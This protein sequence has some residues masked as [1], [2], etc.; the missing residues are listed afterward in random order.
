MNSFSAKMEADYIDEA[1]SENPALAI[2]GDCR[3]ESR[4]SLMKKKA[5]RK[6]YEIEGQRLDQGEVM[7]WIVERVADA[8]RPLSLKALAQ[9]KGAPSLR[10]I[11]GWRRDFPSFDQELTVAENIRAMLLAEE[12]VEVVMDEYDPKAAGLVKAKAESLRWMASK[13]D[14]GKFAD[15]KIDKNDDQFKDSSN[16]QIMDALREAI[17]AN[18][19]ILKTLSY[20]ER[21]QFEE[22]GVI[23][24]TPEPEDESVS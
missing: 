18:S 21:K 11:Y 24:V 4:V 14:P 8:N 13:M 2:P 12:S 6:V 9:K 16:Q 5:A 19:E 10:E 3:L 20:E 7:E 1:L 15:R 17:K 23:E 22:A